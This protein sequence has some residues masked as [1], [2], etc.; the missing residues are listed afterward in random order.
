MLQIAGCGLML[1]TLE[2]TMR[3]DIGKSG[4]PFG[5]ALMLSGYINGSKTLIVVWFDWKKELV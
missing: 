2:G 3:P 4:V 1:T 5:A